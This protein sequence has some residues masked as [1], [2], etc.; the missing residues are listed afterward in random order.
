MTKFRLFSS[1][2]EDSA[3]EYG[4]DDEQFNDHQ[5]SRKRLRN[6][7]Q[8]FNCTP[9]PPPRSRLHS[10]ND[11]LQITPGLFSQPISRRERQILRT[12]E[13]D[14]L[15]LD[16]LRFVNREHSAIQLLRSLRSF[17]L[18]KSASN[19]S[20]AAIEQSYGM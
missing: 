1:R 12:I 3:G 2:E 19:A 9:P 7:A 15:S 20:V 18:Q 4:S 6:V 13:A 16:S 11:Y 17:H 5:R 10:E 14:Q 8:S